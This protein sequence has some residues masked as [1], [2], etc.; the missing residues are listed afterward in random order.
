MQNANN[1]LKTTN[2]AERLSHSLLFPYGGLRVI[3]TLGVVVG[4]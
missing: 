2:T 3:N 4:K 1:V